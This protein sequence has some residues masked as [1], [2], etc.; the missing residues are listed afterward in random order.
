MKQIPIK[1]YQFRE[2]ESIIKKDGWFWVGSEGGHYQYEHK[3]KPGKVT[4][5]HHSKPKDI[6]TILVKRILIQAG[7][8]LPKGD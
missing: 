6:N 2:L 1:P 3:T 5:P 8:I 7:L 4:I